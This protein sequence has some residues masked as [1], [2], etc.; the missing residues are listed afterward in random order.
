MH[1]RLHEAYF[2]ITY[3]S[4]LPFLDEKATLVSFGSTA[5]LAL[6]GVL[7]KL[8]SVALLPSLPL[9]ASLALLPLLPLLALL[10]WLRPLRLFC[11]L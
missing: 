9:L 10:T 4:C 7:H 1:N 3:I 8:F 11:V 2:R 6:V 5:S